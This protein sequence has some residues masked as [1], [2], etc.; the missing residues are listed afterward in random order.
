MR[1]SNE[2]INCI[3][4][5]RKIISFKGIPSNGENTNFIFDLTD[6][7]KNICRTYS[8][9]NPKQEQNLIDAVKSNCRKTV[10]D[11]TGKR[12]Y[13]NVNLVRIQ[14]VEMYL[15]ISSRIFFN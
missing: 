3:W 5:F 7:I 15:S 4:Q 8:L 14:E 2:T 10:R 6:K 12:P 9:N 11:K 13:T 1:L